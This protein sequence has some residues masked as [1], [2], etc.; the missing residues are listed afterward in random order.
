MQ[1]E[2]QAWLGVRSRL[3]LKVELEALRLLPV[4]QQA[5]Y[6]PRN[7][8]A[9]L[10]TLLELLY[11]LRGRAHAKFTQASCTSPGLLFGII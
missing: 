1:V 10:R 6:P 8:T 11:H 4:L 2:S 9:V 7:T 5:Q 3:E